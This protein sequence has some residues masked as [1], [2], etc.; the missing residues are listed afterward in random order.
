M[1]LDEHRVTWARLEISAGGE[2]VT[3]IEDLDSGSSRR[4][5]F[6][7]LYPLAEWISFNWWILLHNSRLSRP[8]AVANFDRLRLV[9]PGY[10]RNNFRSIGDGFAWPDLVIY[11]AGAHTNISWRP[12][13]SPVARW[14][15]RY[16]GAGDCS[17]DSQDLRTELARFVDSV[18]VR[19][20]EC[21]VRGTALQNEWESITGADPEEEQYCRAAARLGLDPYSEAAKHESEILRVAE[22]VPEALLGD[23]MD[24]VDISRTPESLDWISRCMRAVD[25]S[26]SEPLADV[27]SIRSAL[28]A[29]RASVSPFKP[30]ES[31][32][33]QARAARGAASLGPLQRFSPGDYFEVSEIPSPEDRIQAFGKNSGQGGKLIV[34]APQGNART[35]NFLLG[36]ALWHSVAEPE[37][38]FLVT[39]SYTDRQKTERAFAA[40]LL[41]PASGIAELLKKDPWAASL[42]DIDEVA[43]HFQV[44]SVLIKHQIE[45]QLMSAG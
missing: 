13:S 21:G 30:W 1:K 14:K 5:V 12:Y 32:W 31:G 15:I 44:S 45:N 4:S 6:V 27:R 38:R 41:A 37:N 28:T 43:E 26:A 17:V 19:L 39:N 7:P 36:R 34:G 16:I 33:A 25:V 20:E 42:D 22:E 9:D 35:R 3:R 10:K 40:E 11:S 2:T 23:F 18:I 29:R 8:D 24:A